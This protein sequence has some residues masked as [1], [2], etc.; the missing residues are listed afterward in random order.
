MANSKTSHDSQTQN[1]NPA[2]AQNPS[3]AKTTIAPRLRDK[4]LRRAPM[5]LP[6]QI[7]APNSGIDMDELRA[8]LTHI[9]KNTSGPHSNIRAQALTLLKTKLD[10]AKDNAQELFESARLGGLE[11][12]RLLAAIHTDILRIIYDFTTRHI[13]RASNPTPSERIA[14]CAVGGFGRGEMAPGSD[15]DLL[16]LQA[17]KKISAWSE[18]VTEYILYMLWDMGL[19]VGQSS[20]TAEQCINLAHEDQTILTALL[21]CR[22]IAGDDSLALELLTKFRRDIS[23]GNGRGYITAKLTE[24]DERHKREGNSRYVIEPNIKEGK[25]GLRDLHVLYWIARYLDKNGVIND[26]QRADDYVAMGLFDEGAA[27]RFVRAADFLWRTRCHLHYTAGRATESLT[28]DH[29]TKL[30]R[31]MGYASGPVEVAVEKFMRE[32]FTNAREVGALTR[33]ACAKL[34]AEK[35]LLLPKGLDQFLPRSRRALKDKSFII[36]HGRLSFADPMQIRE[37]P[38]LILRLFEI[39]GQKNYDLH[40]DA[41][42]AIDFRRNLVDNNFRKDPKNAKIFL[43]SLLDSSSPAAVMKLMNEAGILGRYLIEFGGI[44]GRTQFNMHHAYTVDDHTLGLVRYFEQLEQGELKD[45]NP[46]ATKF[47]QDFTHSQRR[48]LYM[49]CL[50]HDTGKGV[51]DQCIEGAR[52]SRRAGRRM[53]LDINEIDTI[54]W[55]IR[56]HLDMSETAQRRDISDPETIKSFAEKMGSLERLQLLMALTVV[57]IRAVGPGIWNDWKGSLL[58][59]L[60]L[61]SASYLDDKPNIAPRSRALAAQETLFERLPDTVRTGVEPLMSHLGDNY[62]LSFGITDQVRHARFFNNSFDDGQDHAVH[63]RI[64]KK[65]NITE[66]WV[67]THDRAGLFTAIT[68]AIFASG[69]SISGARLHNYKAGNDDAP[70]I[71]DIFYLQNI[72]GSIFGQDNKR[73]LDLLTKNTLAAARGQEVVIPAAPKSYSKRADAIPIKSSVRFE[74]RPAED[75]V[76][77]ELMGRDRP[78]LLYELAKV[79]TDEGIII[80]SAHIEVVGTMA[81]DSF[82]LKYVQGTDEWRAQKRDRIKNKLLTVLKGKRKNDN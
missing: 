14:V 53:G 80:L 25:G 67:L 6:A 13:V 21:D 9:A 50:L 46:I 59:E 29:Q 27:D 26:P 78:G 3:Q 68:G 18:S 11:S 10:E 24:R 36:D 81:V 54:S 60:Y 73:V 65:A 17:D 42:T 71:F 40:P 74:D 49:A 44:V 38:S 48:I 15:L 57:D 37:N 75:V 52:L 16:F 79:L 69:A 1:Q 70:R 28:F 12:A 63:T 8:Q 35:A 2:Q 76:F 62:W 66:L 23:K 5:S 77:L 31:K 47:V 43:S 45:D 20:R 72:D 56:R 22:F 61:S 34:E 7:S 30:A 32:Y 4:I 19:K 64:N 39:A 82:Y 51:G 55:L 41:L 33:I 58:R